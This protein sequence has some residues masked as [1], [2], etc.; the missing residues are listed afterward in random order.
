[1]LY[2]DFRSGTLKFR[3]VSTGFKALLRTAL[4]KTKFSD[5][6]IKRR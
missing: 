4:F 2:K 5:A 3:S 6:I 1:M